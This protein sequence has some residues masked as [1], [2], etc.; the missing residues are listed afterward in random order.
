V[1]VSHCAGQH[2][3]HLLLQLCTLRTEFPD[4]TCMR[5]PPL[6]HLP[7][8]ACPPLFLILLLL[9]HA[10]APYYPSP[11]ACTSANELS[12]SR[13][14]SRSA[15]RAH[16]RVSLVL[17]HQSFM[18]MCIS[19]MRASLAERGAR[20]HLSQNAAH[21]LDEAIL[22]GNVRPLKLRM[23]ACYCWAGATS[24][25]CCWC[26]RGVTPLSSLWSCQCRY[27]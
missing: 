16:A 4:E 14:V 21:A 19:R 11:H 23:L 5:P 15:S 12:L 26:H 3:E 25:S 1:L 24:H 27:A 8:T 13:S 17:T 20:V 9:L 22:L 6:L 7:H 10:R 2:Q 18:R